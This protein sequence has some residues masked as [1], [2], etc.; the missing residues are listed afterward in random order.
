VNNRQHQ[1]ASVQEAVMRMGSGMI[2]GLAMGASTRPMVA[3][4][5]PG[6][7]LKGDDFWEHAVTAALVADV[8]RSFAKTPWS[9]AGFTAALLHD[10]GKLVLGKFISAECRECLR[11]AVAVG[12]LEPYQ[13]EFEVLSVHHAEVGALIAQHWKLPG[14]IVQ[15]ILH[16]HD[17]DEDSDI[18]AH[19]TYLAN[20][21][22]KGIQDGQGVDRAQERLLPVLRRLGLHPDSMGKIAAKVTARFAELREHY[23]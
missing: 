14:N 10:I 5:I 1:A 3:A 9:P 23:L 7:D 19:V 11:D 13:A 12:G 8:S 4:V 18:L 6:Y 2:L 16:H 21:A 15:G 22:A 20:V 17:P